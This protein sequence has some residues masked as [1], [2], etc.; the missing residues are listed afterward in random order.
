MKG[1]ALVRMIFT[2]F[3]SQNICLLDQAFY[4]DDLII[5]SVM[6]F[7][8]QNSFLKASIDQQVSGYGSLDGATTKFVN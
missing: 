8:D 7:L 5:F 2:L 1:L 3:G 6:S 4:V